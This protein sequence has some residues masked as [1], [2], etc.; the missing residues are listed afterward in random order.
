ALTQAEAPAGEPANDNEIVVL[1]ERLRSIRLSPGVTIRKGVVTPGTCKIK[2]SSGDAEVDALAGDAVALCGTRP[3]P[4][5]KAFNTCVDK[6]AIDAIFRLRGERA[7]RKA[8]L[9]E[10]GEAGQ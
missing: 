9:I 10:A 4:S 1:T 7:A 6:E 8:A 3:Q 2:R 5:R